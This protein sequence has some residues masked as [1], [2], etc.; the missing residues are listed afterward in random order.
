MDET[1]V[2][3]CS[4]M[5]DDSFSTMKSVVTDM[6]ENGTEY[7]TC[8]EKQYDNA[9]NLAFDWG[10]IT[11]GVGMVLAGAV[12]YLLDKRKIKKEKYPWLKD[13]K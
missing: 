12:Y 3:D 9:Q 10:V 4:F 6:S 8:T 1:K 2:L 11:A 7:V 5:D 13:K